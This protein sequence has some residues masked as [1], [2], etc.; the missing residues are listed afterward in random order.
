MSS[1]WEDQYIASKR[2]FYHWCSR[3]AGW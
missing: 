1:G 2:W 3:G